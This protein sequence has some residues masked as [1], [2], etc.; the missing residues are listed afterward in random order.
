MRFRHESPQVREQ[1]D[2]QNSV[3][4]VTGGAAGIGRSVA[5]EFA[6]EGADVAIADID[7]DNGESVA[8]EIR[9]EFG[10]ASQYVYM[11]VSDYES[12]TDGI[13]EVVEEFGGV[14][15]LVNTAAYVP[16]DPEELS[17]LFIDESPDSWDPQVEV[18]FRGPINVNHAVLPYMKEQGEGA[19]VNFTSDS[20]QG[21]D[22]GIA[23]Y[24]AAK[25][26]I[27]SFTKTLAKEVGEHGIRVN[28]IAPSTTWTESNE[29]FLEQYGDKIV[30]QYPLSRLGEGEDHAYATLFLASDAA[31][32]LTGQVVSVNGGF[33]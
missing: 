28:A 20:Y 25:G 31:D 9:E 30:Q 21:Q 18:T 15:V 26:G 16:T 10:Q 7:D 14:D 27:V 33:L 8:N 12:C 6:S 11:D 17:T 1:I 19:I 3:A 2:F 32:W 23:V 4:I 22:P 24:A 13:E 29:D 5:L